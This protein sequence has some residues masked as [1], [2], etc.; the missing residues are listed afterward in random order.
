MKHYNVAICLLTCE[1]DHL[2]EWYNHHKKMG[3]ENF[4]IFVDG[5]FADSNYPNKELRNKILKLQILP[6]KYIND[7]I[8]TILI[9]GLL[10]TTICKRY[11]YFD[12][13]LFIDSDEYYMSK[14]GNIIKDVNFLKELHGDFDGLGIYWRKYGSQPPF[15]N[16]QPIDSYKQWHGS[17]LIKSLVNPKS[18]AVFPNS[19]VAQGNFKKYI[20]EKGKIVDTRLKMKGRGVQHSSDYVWIKHI[21]TRSKSEWLYKI[22]R[23]NWY[24]KR[25]QHKLSLEWFEEYQLKCQN[26]DA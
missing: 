19:H 8:N 2:E 22:S 5:N 26:R 15:E 18:V 9:F 16:R 23:E 3:F 25:H 24:Q 7:I 4:L 10:Y 6:K 14:T 13:I 1:L 17:P 21:L 12:Y 20:D 11:S